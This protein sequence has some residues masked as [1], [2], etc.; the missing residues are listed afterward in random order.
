MK[1]KHKAKCI[2]RLGSTFYLAF[3][4]VASA[5]TLPGGTGNA[6][7][8]SICGSCHAL[9]IVTK[10]RMT[11]AEWA[12]VVNNM[13]LRG[14][15]GSP[16]DLDKVVTYL[17]TNFGKNSPFPSAPAPAQTAPAAEEHEPPLREAEISKARELIQ[18]NKCLSCHCIEDTGSYLGPELTDIGTNRSVKQLRDSLMSPNKEAFPENRLVRVITRD[19]KTFTGRLLNHDSYSVQFIQS[20]GQI[21]SVQKA[22]ANSRS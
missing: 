22:F 18:A 10:Q 1:Q 9:I 19:G 8:Q 12:G 3:T 13:V 17:A 5:Q 15:H 6:E 2:F 21:E 11:R 7:F 14:A 20:S 4:F 16:E